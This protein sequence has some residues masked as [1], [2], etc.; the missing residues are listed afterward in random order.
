VGQPL[1]GIELRLAPVA[2]SEET[3]R[4]GNGAGPAEGEI[5]ALGV[6]VFAGYRNLP[7]QTAQA[8]TED[9]WFRTGDLGYVDDAGYFYISGRASTLIVLEGGKKIQPE[10]LEEIYDQHQ[11]IREIGILYEDKQLVALIV[12]EIEAVNRLRNGDVEQAI[13][14]AVGERVQAVPTYQRIS[15]YAITQQPLARTNLG[16][17]RRHDLVQNYREAKQGIIRDDTS[18]GPVALTDMSEQ[19]QALLAHPTA[20]Q[21]WAWLAERYPDKRLAPDSSPQFDLGVDSLEWLNI[22]LNI[23]ELTGVE[24]S[25]EAIARVTTVRDLLREVV[26]VA[27]SEEAPPAVLDHPEALLS[28]EQKQWLNPPSPALQT[29]FGLSFPI[30]QWLMRLM[31]KVKAQGLENLPQQ[32][33]FVLTPNHRSLLDAPSVA[34]VLTLAQ[35]RQTHWAGATD[36]MLSNGFMRFISRMSQVLP[37]ERFGASG[38]KNLALALVALQR[39]KNL[40]WFPEGHLVPSDEMLPFLEGIGLVLQRQPVPVVPVYIQGTREAMPIDAAIPKP[41][42]I[43]VTFGPPCDPHELAREGEGDTFAARLVQA[44]QAR[45]MALREQER[46]V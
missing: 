12:P 9:G 2:Q 25:E 34:A 20:Q 43:T 30:F 5:Q 18:A 29:V 16:K 45:V 17:I 42:Q 1:P 44:L 3:D 37:I 14:E 19:D 46:S 28:D 4:Q 10:P 33:N 13:R 23:H 32:G 6:S 21:V 36:I 38:M 11:F 8:F 27:E 40:V 26:T 15:D 22:T 39:G 41:G 31:F 24:L 7:D 35:M